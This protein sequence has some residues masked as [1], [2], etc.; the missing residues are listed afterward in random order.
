MGDS[1]RAQAKPAPSIAAFNRLRELWEETFLSLAPKEREPYYWE[2]DPN[3]VPNG[4]TL[5]AERGTTIDTCPVCR[6]TML[7]PPGRDR[8]RLCNTQQ[9]ID[10]LDCKSFGDITKEKERLRKWQGME[11]SREDAYEA[12]KGKAKRRGARK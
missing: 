12:E 9:L 8:C 2:E 3:K 6:R 11:Q 5:T 10:Q 4:P 7:I 1:F